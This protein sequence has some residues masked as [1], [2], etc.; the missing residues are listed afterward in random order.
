MK[1]LIV[2]LFML[3]CGVS[4]AQWVLC[5]SSK[6]GD[7]D[8]FVRAGSIKVEADLRTALILF[9]YNFVTDGVKSSVAMNEYDCS[10]KKVRTNYLIQYTK[11]MA[12]GDVMLATAPPKDK[13]YWRPATDGSV[14]ASI[15]KLVCS[16]DGQ[17]PILRS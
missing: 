15:M 4:H 1:K 17:L 6:N 12:K 2:V 11:E 9:N 8:F 13:D 14:T 5:G 10:S 7:F 16:H 3:V